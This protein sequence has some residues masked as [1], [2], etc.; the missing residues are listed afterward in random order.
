MTTD[1]K[2]EAKVLT[3]FF[4]SVFNSQTSYPWSTLPSDLKVWDGDYVEKSYLL[5]HPDCHKSMGLNGV[6]SR[7][8]GKLAE[9]IAK[10]F[11]TICQCSWINQRGLTGLEA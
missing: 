6:H 4:M 7:V 11:S 2:E 3:A 1:D 8:L 5:L 9:V 10:L